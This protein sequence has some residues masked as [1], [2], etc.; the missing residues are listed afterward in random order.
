MIDRLVL[1]GLVAAL[2]AVPARAGG[3]EGKSYIIEMSSSQYSS[4]YADY[5]V[6]PLAA[7]LAK[8]AMKPL[9]GPGADV[10]VNVVTHSDVGQ[11]IGEGEG[12]QWLYT[13]S[14]T[15]GISPGDYQIPVDGTPQFGV[16]AS[17]MTP[18]G[19]RGDEMA[20]LIGL[21][22]GQ[23]IARYRPAGMIEI[24]GKACLRK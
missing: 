17:L 15:V 23:A 18:N 24:D 16:R 13:V 7:A 14:I 19:D 22:A 2:G 4:G 6:P 10:A 3:L 21:A 8:S 11:W 5:L 12:R 9:K 20:C 1:A